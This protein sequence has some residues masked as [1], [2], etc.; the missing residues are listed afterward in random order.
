MRG[1][2]ILADQV[3]C[4]FPVFFETRLIFAVADRGNI[5][6]ERIEPDIADIILVERQFDPPCKTRFRTR[7]AEIFER[8]LQEAERFICAVCGQNEIRMSLDVFD[9]PVLKTA[10]AE[11]IVG[12]HDVSGRSQTVRT[13]IAVHKILIS[14]EAFAGNAVMPLVFRFVNQIAVIKILQSHLHDFLVPR[15]GR[16]DEIIVFDPEFLP[17]FLKTDNGPFALFDRSDPVRFSCFLDLLTM[18]IGSGQE[19]GII[20]HRAMIAGHNIAE[21]GRVCVT[22]MR[23]I[24]HIINRCGHVKY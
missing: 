1:K 19:P 21:N 10:H 3:M 9:Q 12:F 8:F 4:L 13:E 6:D 14:E 16:A 17:E 22:D 2:D 20:F 24:I 23:F 11:E 5:I 7:D 15:L 18:L